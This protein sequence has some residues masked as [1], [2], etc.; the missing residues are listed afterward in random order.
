VRDGVGVGTPP[1]GLRRIAWI[2]SAPLVDTVRTMN[3]HSRNFWAEVLG[4]RLGHDVAGR[5]TIAGGATAICGFASAH[6]L[7]FSCH[8]GSG[9]SYANRASALGIVQLLWYADDRPWGEA[10]RSTLPTGGQG[11]L[12]DRL[13][14]VKLRAKTGTLEDVSAL[15][16]WVWSRVSS[17]WLEF[18]I[19]S[20]G[21]DDRAAKSIEDQIVKIVS[22]SATDPTP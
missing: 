19:M 20:S 16:G 13:L 9:L 14:Q 7:A 2:D 4:K 11:T 8:D 22:A 15:S 1:A 5:G 12:E 17:E 18:S 21:Y 6:G 10:L 3:V